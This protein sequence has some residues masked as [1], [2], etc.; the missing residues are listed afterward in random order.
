MDGDDVKL[1]ELRK[2]LRRRRPE[3]PI[4]V[5][6][7]HAVGGCTCEPG[8]AHIRNHAG[9]R[10]F[11]LPTE[12]NF[13]GPHHDRDCTKW[14]SSFEC[15]CMLPGADIVHEENCFRGLIEA[16]KKKP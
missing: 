12:K 4:M 8:P 15:T 14:R 13:S 11:R 5:G 6:F 2:H 16:H 10:I 7:S 3:D 1:E 9:K